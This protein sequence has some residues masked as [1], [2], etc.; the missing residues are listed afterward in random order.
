MGPGIWGFVIIL[1]IVIL[2]FGP[3]NLPKLG[4]ALGQFMRELR[5]VKDDLPSKD[6]FSLEPKKPADD[7]PKSSDKTSSSDDA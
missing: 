5:N 3:S 1:V 2:I 6:D 4:K 7:K